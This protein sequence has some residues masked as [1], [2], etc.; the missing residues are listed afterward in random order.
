[1]AQKVNRV[2]RVCCEMGDANPIATI[3]D[4]G[5]GGNCNVLKEIV[6]P[7]GG[8]INVCILFLSSFFS[9]HN[10][11]CTCL[12]VFILSH[13]QIRDIIVG[14]ASMS[15]LEI[16]GAEYQEADALL[17]HEKDVSMFSLICARERAPVAFVGKVDGTGRVKLVDSRDNTTPVDMDLERVLGQMPQKEFVSS[18]KKSKLEKFQLPP[19]GDLNV[20]LGR[21]LR[22]LSVGS[23]RFLTNKVDRAVTGL[24]AQQ[25]CVG[26]LHTPLADVSVIALSHVETV[27]TASSIGEQPLKGLV[28]PGALGRMS[29]AEAITNLASARIRGGLSSVKCSAN[30]M[31]ASK[32]PHEG[33]ALYDAAVA[34][35]DF[36]IQ[37]CFSVSF[38]SFLISASAFIHFYLLSLFS[39]L[40]WYCC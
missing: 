14:D 16:W 25:Q 15:V 21:V 6:A 32:L 22:L 8:V 31:W 4:Q 30:W 36:M 9:T 7:A 29:V 35:A 28:S 11:S 27:G 12:C 24:I 5:A 1:M 39:T 26:P 3:H 40:D 38:S 23:K 34:M 19:W 20:C 13:T 33:A 18:R 37:V 10:V 17:I 2:I